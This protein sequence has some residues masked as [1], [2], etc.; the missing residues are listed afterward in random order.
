MRSVRATEHR[1]RQT[2]SGSD[3][4]PEMWGFGPSF[5]PRLRTR[6]A[7]ESATIKGDSPVV[8]SKT[9][10]KVSRVL[11]PGYEAG[12]W[13]TLTSNRKYVLRPIAY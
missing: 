10:V 2:E 1:K 5:R 7:L 8:K 12:N 9:A 4:L 13:E 3:E 6:S 11:L